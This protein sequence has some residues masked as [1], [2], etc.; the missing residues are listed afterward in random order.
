MVAPSDGTL[1][2]L[3]ALPP[4]TQAMLK[5]SVAFL[6]PEVE[7]QLSV[8]RE[9][10]QSFQEQTE[11]AGFM[12]THIL[13]VVSMCD[14]QLVK[15]FSRVKHEDAKPPHCAQSCVTIRTAYE[16]AVRQLKG[17]FESFSECDMKV[18]PPAA[19]AVW[20]SWLPRPRNPFCSCSRCSPPD[21]CDS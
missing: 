13:R 9:K 16:A 5:A 17:V 11:R 7:E 4:L 2:R 6:N 19:A 20:L 18:T 1:Y 10:I 14:R 12:L 15:L 3:G 8:C 21:A